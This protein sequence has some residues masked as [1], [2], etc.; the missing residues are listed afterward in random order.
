[1]T[2]EQ[3]VTKIDEY[4]NQ[5]DGD[6]V[7]VYKSIMQYEQNAERYKKDHATKLCRDLLRIISSGTPKEFHFFLSAIVEI[8]GNL[9]VFQE[10]IRLCA[11][12][13][14]LSKEQ[15]YFAY[16]QLLFYKFT[17]PE[18]NCKAVVDLLDELYGTIY[19][20]YFNEIKGLY[21]KIPKEE[22]NEEFVIVM[23]SQV[24]SM[25]HGPTKTLLDRCYIMAER[26]HK[27]IYIIN[28]AD[29]LP[30]DSPILWYN[31]HKG[32]YDAAL[33]EK[34]YLTYK[35]FEFPFFQCPDGA[36][37]VSV[38]REILQIVAEEKPWCIV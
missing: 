19:D 7:D 9:E 32:N 33:N 8:T 4:W 16:C 3:L 22:R 5:D 21:K 28:T 6:I 13:S 35:N 18:V 25:E 34:E 15:R 11:I 20:A 31:A 26:L 30:D 1:M 24:L 12:D 38:I 27:K 17:H 23:T 36:P 37:D 14:S 2:A 10:L 29:T